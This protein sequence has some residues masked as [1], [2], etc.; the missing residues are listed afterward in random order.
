MKRLMMIA[1]LGAVIYGCAP[2]VTVDSNSRVNFNK[3]RTY[4]WMDSDIEAGKIHCIT[5]S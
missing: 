4:A 1:V 3:Y 2:R 5:T